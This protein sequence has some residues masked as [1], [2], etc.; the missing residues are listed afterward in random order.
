[1]VLYARKQRPAWITVGAG[2][3]IGLVTGLLGGWIA[4]AAMS[5][6]LFALRFVF[7]DGR[8]FDNFWQNQV[9]EKVSQQWASAG[10]DAQTILV[11][12]AMLNS[13]EGRGGVTFSVILFLSVGL[14]LFATGGG[15]LGARLMARRRQPEI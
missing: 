2:A 6:T 15:A 1:M 14:V 11:A 10:L 13:P 9:S 5:A 12:K 4:A 8:I 7:H 3:R